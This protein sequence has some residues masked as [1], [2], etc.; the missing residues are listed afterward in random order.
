VTINHNAYEKRARAEARHRRGE[1]RRAAGN[2]RLS[3]RARQYEWWAGVLDRFGFTVQAKEARVEAKRF[4]AQAG[5]NDRY[6]R[7]E[8]WL[9]R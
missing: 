1:R 5:W 6:G 7:P 8:D 2:A 9:P 3:A 4:R